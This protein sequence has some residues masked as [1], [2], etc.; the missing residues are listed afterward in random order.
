MLFCEA[1]TFL[2]RADWY[3]A[4]S[5]EYMACGRPFLGARLDSHYCPHMAG[6][7][8]YPPNW[9]E[10]APS[11]TR[12]PRYEAWDI[13]C[14]HEIHPATAPAKTI[15]QIWRPG[16]WTPAMLKR[17]WSTTG[18]FHQDKKGELYDLIP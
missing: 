18:L 7:G 3:E 13:A 11:L 10:W 16:K 4:I 2:C 17:I 6:C 1:D 14:A 12:L 15:Q 9:R 5:A 8:V